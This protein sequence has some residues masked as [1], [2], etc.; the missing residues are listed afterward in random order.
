[1]ECIL[2]EKRLLAVAHHVIRFAR[3]HVI[4]TLPDKVAFRVYS[5]L[6][7]ALMRCRLY[8]PHSQGLPPMDADKS[9]GG[10]TDNGAVR[11]SFTVPIDRDKI[12]RLDSEE[13]IQ[14]EVQRLLPDA[15]KEWHRLRRKAATK[16]FADYME[17]NPVDGITFTTNDDE[18]TE[19]DTG[20]I[21][22]SEGELAF[23][24]NNIELNLRAIQAE[25]QGTQPMDADKISAD[26]NNQVALSIKEH[27]TKKPTGNTAADAEGLVDMLCNHP[28]VKERCDSRYAAHIIRQVYTALSVP[29]PEGFDKV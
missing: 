26:A 3:E 14:K 7:R 5:W 24:T 6:Y 8:T 19:G 12:P 4:Q 28:R 22:L 17:K 27:L 2:F 13:T 21:E 9:V 16:L 23:V 1:M 18:F 20:E 11:M 29:Y 10:V 25:Q 15:K